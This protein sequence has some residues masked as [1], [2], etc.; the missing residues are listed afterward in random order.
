[1]QSS[2]H[3]GI[4]G[5]TRLY[6]KKSDTYV[7]L[8]HDKHVPYQDKKKTKGK[9]R[10]ID[11]YH[12][13]DQS[14]Y[15]IVKDLNKNSKHDI[16]LIYEG[17]RGSHTTQTGL[18][19]IDSAQQFESELGKKVR[20]TYADYGRSYFDRA[21]RSFISESIDQI[22]T[23][24]RKLKA[25]IQYEPGY[26]PFTYITSMKKQ[27]FGNILSSLSTNEI[28]YFF[29]KAMLRSIDTDVYRLIEKNYG[30]SCR[31]SFE[32]KF[33][34]NQDFWKEYY[35]KN[36]EKFE[37]KSLAYFVDNGGIDV[38]AHIPC[39]A[40]PCRSRVP[41]NQIPEHIF[42]NYQNICDIDLLFHILSC[43]KKQTIVYAGGAHCKE[44]ES[45][46]KSV[47]FIEVSSFSHGMNSASFLKS[48]Q[49]NHLKNIQIT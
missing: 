4:F 29:K 3:A 32:K 33:K 17:Y 1:V 12:P 40:E 45:F 41:Y 16:E 42:F 23:E 25:D 5:Y 2:L 19:L 43:G 39:N 13:A 24:F 48:H 30:L 26:D 49:L 28:I 34:N 20:L 37:N 36:I 35:A 47:G 8:I 15:H 31:K 46:L 10:W 14:F 27:G 18:F 6:N 7:D 11:T 22:D 38:L 9:P 44:V 21:L